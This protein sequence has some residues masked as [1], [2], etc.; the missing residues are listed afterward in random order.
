MPYLGHF[1]Q[2]SFRLT[3][4]GKKNKVSD[5]S[6]QSETAKQRW[7]MSGINHDGTEEMT[8]DERHDQVYADSD[9]AV[10]LGVSVQATAQ[11]RGRKNVC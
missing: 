6:I 5:R 11:C 7:L 9:G 3:T 1:L 10:A 2:M 4:F 8:S